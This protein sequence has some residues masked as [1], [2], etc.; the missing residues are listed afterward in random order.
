MGTR[1]VIIYRGVDAGM[2]SPVKD[3]ENSVIK[4]PEQGAAALRCRKR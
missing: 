3:V 4:S 2:F 1:K